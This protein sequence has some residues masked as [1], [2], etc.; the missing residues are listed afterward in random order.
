M[1][2]KEKVTRVLEPVRK[3]WSSEL[4]DYNKVIAHNSFAFPVITPTVGIVD[5]TN[6]DINHLDIKRRKILCITGNFHPNSDI[7]KLYISRK[8][9][10]R[11]LKEI[12]TMHES[13]LIAIRQHLLI[14][15]SRNNIMGYVIECEQSSIIK[16]GNELLTNKNITENPDEKPKSLNKKYTAEKNE[17]A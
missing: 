5:W 17:R 1:L 6:H 10:R 7:D 16:V 12:K 14:N 15:N 3:I 9:G 8:K 11:G 13:R 2:N 4:L